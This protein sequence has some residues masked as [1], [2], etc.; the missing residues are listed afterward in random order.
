MSEGFS[1]D[2]LALR[3]PYD[4]RSRS[5]MLLD[6]L[7][8][9]RRDRGRLRIVDLGSGT[10]SNLRGTAG[11]LGGD[12]DWTLVEWDRSLIASG[13]RL[14]GDASVGWRYRRLDLA[15]ELERVDF[16]RIDVITASALI[17]L[18][19]SDWLDQ[20][21]RLRRRT[22]AALYIVLSYEGGIVWEPSNPLDA[23]VG[24]LVD[25]H[26]CTDKGFGPA[27]GPAAVETLRERCTSCDGELVSDTSDWTLGPADQA[28]QIALLAGY[29]AASI[30]IVPERAVELNG[31][32]QWRRE[33][34]V[35]GGS[36]LR[37]RHRDLL[38]LA[39]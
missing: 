30:A 3:E 4:R 25:A 12:Q 37:V 9:W 13:K 16:E 14:L 22:G 15:R 2:W 33:R 21:V 1:S 27:L 26:Q 7:A 35:A 38:L 11:A 6:R 23:T 32:A 20:L 18:V 19:S 5:P 10:G 29:E 24:Q 28:M 34:I 31:W 17:D 39:A 36:Y 8:A